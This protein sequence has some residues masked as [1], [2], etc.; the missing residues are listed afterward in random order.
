MSEIGL[1]V[2]NQ[3]EMVVSSGEQGGAM[4]FS[5][6]AGGAAITARRLATA[7]KIGLGG[8][9]VGSASFDGS[10]DME[11]MTAVETLSNAELEAMLV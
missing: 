3:A 11:I 7:R 9:A 2:G 5:A 8:D 4:T 10:A 1:T 6:E